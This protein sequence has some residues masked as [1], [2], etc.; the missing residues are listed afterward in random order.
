MPCRLPGSGESFPAVLDCSEAIEEEPSSFI[1][2][3]PAIEVPLSPSAQ[4][5]E[6][7]IDWLFLNRQPCYAIGHSP[8]LA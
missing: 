6:L 7:I 4:H 2:T 3:Q 8:T 5:I 1:D